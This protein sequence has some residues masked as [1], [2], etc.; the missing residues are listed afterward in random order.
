MGAK[1]FRLKQIWVDDEGFPGG[2]RK[3]REAVKPTEPLGQ[4]FDE[5]VRVTA[6]IDEDFKA[7]LY[8]EL[9]FYERG[10]RELRLL[11]RMNPDLFSIAKPEL[12]RV[13]IEQELF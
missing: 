5:L 3:P 10:I 6:G 7:R 2:G 11:S 4:L 12:K 9:A 13:N 8:G 1:G